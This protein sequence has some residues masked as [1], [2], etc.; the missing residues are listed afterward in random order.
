MWTC[1]WL[2]CIAF[3]FHVE[4]ARPILSAK[5]N[6][7]EKWSW[8]NLLGLGGSGVERPD[9]WD[10]LVNSTGGTPLPKNLWQFWEQEDVQKTAPQLNQLALEMWPALNPTWKYT[11]VTSRNLPSLC[12]DLHELFQSKPGNVQLRSDMIRLAL[13]AEHGGVWADSSLLPLRGLDTFANQL[14]LQTGFFVFTY[15]DDQISSWFIASQPKNTLILTWLDAFKEKWRSRNVS[16]F[17]YF[18]VHYTL[19]EL[20]PEG[21]PRIVTVWKDMPRIGSGW[22]QQ[23]TGQA[24]PDLWQTADALDYPPVLK[25]PCASPEWL[26][27]YRRFVQHGN[28][29]G[30]PRSPQHLGL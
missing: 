4:C 18:E 13:L 2:V 17:R 1:T 21:D 5:P 24:C 15:P 25:R 16:D 19:Q 23:C 30:G 28:L 22:P 27:G 6:G 20:I 12:P 26:Q 10:S 3:I 29:L 11:L 9:N 7:E 8:K 14:V